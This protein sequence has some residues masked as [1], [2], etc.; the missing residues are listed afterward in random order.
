MGID[1]LYLVRELAGWNDI[2]MKPEKEIDYGELNIDYLNQQ[3]KRLDAGEVFTFLD[4]EESEMQEI[5]EKHGIEELS[6]VLNRIFDGDLYDN[7]YYT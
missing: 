2:P 6:G 5:V 3:A 1:F 7:F 4:G